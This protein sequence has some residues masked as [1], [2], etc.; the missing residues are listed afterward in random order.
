V[1]KSFEKAVHKDVDEIGPRVE[2]LQQ[3]LLPN[4]RTA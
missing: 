1:Q 2:H 3:A 4:G